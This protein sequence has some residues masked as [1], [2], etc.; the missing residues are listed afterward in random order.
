MR[1]ESGRSSITKPRKKKAPKQ[2]KPKLRYNKE[3]V[4]QWGGVRRGGGCL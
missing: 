3:G 4:N 1:K 2:K